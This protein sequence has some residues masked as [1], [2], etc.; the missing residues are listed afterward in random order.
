MN[1]ITCYIDQQKAEL[2][3]IWTS[4]FLSEAEKHC[5]QKRNIDKHVVVFGRT[6]HERRN[7]KD[8]FGQNKDGS[9]SLP[10]AKKGPCQVSDDSSKS[11]LS[12]ESIV[13]VETSKI[14][15]RQIMIS[16]H[17]VDQAR[18]KRKRQINYSLEVQSSKQN[19]VA[20][21]INSITRIVVQ[22]FRK[23]IDC[24]RCALFLMDHS[25]D[26]LYF[27]PVGD[28]HDADP[29]E[30]RFPASSGV[31]GF[32]ATKAVT[33]NIR[34]A[35]HDARF[36]SEIDK[37]TNFRTRSI[38]C[39]P[40]LSSTGHLFGVIQMVNKKKGD[41][42]QIQSMAKKKK[43]DNKH[44]G[45]ASCF[46][47][48]STEDEQI[49]DLCCSRVSKSLEAILCPNKTIGKD[50]NAVQEISSELPKRNRRASTASDLSHKDRRRSS[51]GNLVQFVSS[52]DARAKTGPVKP[53]QDIL[54]GVG[55]CEA[56]T[57]F[58]FRT[59]IVGPQMSAKVQ[60]KDDPERLM[61]AT[62]RKRMVDY[63]LQRKFRE[64]VVVV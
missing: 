31:A 1:V 14:K 29:K 55:V 13:N 41:S 30:I 52:V 15:G 38:L 18:E 59:T 6:T 5:I 9:T 39:A 20:L 32:V 35:Y 19:Y 50:D 7:T 11:T 62:K 12:K 34:D 27:K 53:S 23:L 47:P 16:R 37:Q 4:A 64:K 58:Q 24:E 21:Q 42:K 61:A 22:S 44:H 36:N 57:K 17:D 10:N 26:E 43:T 40:V 54:A 8:I 46:E 45:Y 3:E 49:L 56:L 48:F 25:T 51:V 60:Q 63:N 2:I 28:E 33:L